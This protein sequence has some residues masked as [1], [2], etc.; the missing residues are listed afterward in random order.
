MNNG[1]TAEFFPIE[2]G[3]HMILVEYNGV[4][5]E[6]AHVYHPGRSII[7]AYRDFYYHWNIIYK[8][9]KYQKKQGQKPMRAG[10]GFRS[11]QSYFKYK[12]KLRSA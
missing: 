12:R 7:R 5:A 11:V 9:A 4:A 10:Q 1:F 3:I 8:I 6:P 2:V